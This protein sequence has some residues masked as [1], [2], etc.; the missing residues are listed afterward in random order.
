MLGDSGPPF[1]RRAALAIIPA[2]LAGCGSINSFDKPDETSFFLVSTGGASLIYSALVGEVKYC[3]VTQHNLGKSEYIAEVTFD[4]KNCAA[5][6]AANNP[7][8]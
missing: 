6:A 5:E 1:L 3:K 4:G 2:I 7:E 8:N